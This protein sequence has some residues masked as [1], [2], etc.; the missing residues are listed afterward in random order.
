MFLSAILATVALF[1]T[2]LTVLADTG[3]GPIP[4]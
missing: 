4:K 2:V 3:G 1:G